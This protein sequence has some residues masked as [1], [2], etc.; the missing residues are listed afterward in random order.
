M[1]N[2]SIKQKPSQPDKARKPLEGYARYTNLAFQMF[3]I[4]GI[5]IFAGVKLDQ[6]LNLSFPVF[7]LIL[8]IL[9]VAAAIYSAIKDL[10]R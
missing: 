5:G 9:S 3:A 2:P 10:I 6:W 7:T 8:S 4:I 1:K